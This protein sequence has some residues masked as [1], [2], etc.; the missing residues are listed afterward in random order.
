MENSEMLLSDK[1]EQMPIFTRSVNFSSDN[2]NQERQTL[3]INGQPTVFS[4]I[5]PDLQ[6]QFITDILY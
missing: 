3:L 6:K 2:N 5:V 1:A 4:E